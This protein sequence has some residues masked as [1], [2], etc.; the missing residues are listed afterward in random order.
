MF[1]S[2]FAETIIV[3]LAIVMGF[4]MSLASAIINRKGFNFSNIFKIWSMITTVI[5]LA[6]TSF[7]K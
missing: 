6:S 7:N 3:V 2:H 4:I 1:K 5:L